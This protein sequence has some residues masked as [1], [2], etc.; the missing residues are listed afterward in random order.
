MDPHRTT[1]VGL[2]ITG[3]SCVRYLHGVDELMVVDTRS[4]PPGLAL[5]QAEFPDVSLAIGAERIDFSGVD[6][7][8][9]SPGVALDDPLLKGLPEDLPL[10]SDVDLFCE[11]ARAPIIAV[12]GTN[13]KSTVTSMVGHI[14]SSSG[15][16]AVVG[17]NLGVAALDLLDDTAQVYV[18]ELSSFQ[19]ER[20]S[21]HRFL[22]ATILN[23]SEDHLD[24]HGDMVAYVGAKQRIYRDCEQA[25]ACRGDRATFPEADCP[26]VT[27]GDDEPSAGQWGLRQIENERWLSCGEVAMLASERLPIAGLHNELNALAALALASSL[28]ISRDCMAEAVC[29]FRGL[30]HRCERVGRV[31]GVDFINDSKATN[32][33]ATCAALL[34]LGNQ[35]G[36]A[37]TKI[38]LIAGGDGKGADFSALADVV[39]KHVK[40]LVLLG[41]DG[42]RL[43]EALAG[44]AQV[45]I[46]AH[47]SEAVGVAARLAISGDLVLLSPAC[48]SLDMYS[49]FAARGDDFG[50][51]VEALAA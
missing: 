14:L 13:G 27:F 29:T 23:V 42:P 19:L 39:A 15:L 40:A 46:V 50:R 7:L 21:P 36:D 6:R 43:A 12:T 24:R 31:N 4:S 44:C 32:V 41:R 49:N 37:V 16:A 18:L 35:A 2:G 34:G 8:L 28:G 11:A 20:L 26:V 45:H 9:I 17:G 3:M 22:A 33:G 1:I 30:A 47:M 10:I 25:V 38:I 5:L 51:A 48:S